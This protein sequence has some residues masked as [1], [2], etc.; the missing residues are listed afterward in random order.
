[1]SIAARAMSSR[2]VS[3]I[4]FA[5]MTRG[6]AL[7]RPGEG[8]PDEGRKTLLELRGHRLRDLARGPGALLRRLARPQLDVSVG[9]V[10]A[11][12]HGDGVDQH[13]EA[14]AELDGEGPGA[15]ARLHAG[16]N[17]F[18]GDD[19]VRRHDTQRPGSAEDACR[20]SRSFFT[21]SPYDELRMM[22]SNCVR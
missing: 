15:V 16:G 7:R 21:S 20:R 8:A 4:S 3:S 13:L 1:M 11:E 6:T 17:A 18:P 22:R 9:L 2:A 10:Q 12:L 5:G 14:L 19:L